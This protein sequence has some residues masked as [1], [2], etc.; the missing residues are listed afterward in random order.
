MWSTIRCTP[1]V[2]MKGTSWCYFKISCLRDCGI[3]TCS[4][5]S[6]TRHNI[7][8]RDFWK[9]G[10]LSAFLCR[11]TI[12]WMSGSAIWALRNCWDFILGNEISEVWIKLNNSWSWVCVESTSTTLGLDGNDPQLLCHLY[13]IYFCIFLVSSS[14]TITLLWGVWWYEV[15]VIIWWIRCGVDWDSYLFSGVNL[16]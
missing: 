3:N 5:P 15:L 12:F 9:C 8:W 14:T 1:T 4:R 7:P 6:S 11:A 10:H 2:P 16:N 13:F